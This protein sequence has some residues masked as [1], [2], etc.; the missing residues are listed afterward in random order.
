MEQNN[1]D[2]YFK[3]YFKRSDNGDAV[4]NKKNYNTTT[5]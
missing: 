4:Q 1:T 5:V 3:N 2:N